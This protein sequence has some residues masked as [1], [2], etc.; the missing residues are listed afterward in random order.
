MSP[1]KEYICS[2]REG[3]KKQQIM[4]TSKY[5]FNFMFRTQALAESLSEICELVGIET[6]WAPSAVS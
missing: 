6:G 4:F 5:A 1:L 3:V 2:R